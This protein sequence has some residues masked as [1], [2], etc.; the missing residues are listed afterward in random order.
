MLVRYFWKGGWSADVYG[1]DAFLTGH[2]TSSSR[3]SPSDVTL[4]GRVSEH[5]RWKLGGDH[6]AKVH[7]RRQGSR[8]TLKGT[9]VGKSP[10]WRRRMRSWRHTTARHVGSRTK[11]FRKFSPNSSC[12][13]RVAVYG[14]PGGNTMTIFFA[15]K[16]AS[17]NIASRTDWD[18]N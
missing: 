5:R 16:L 6:L 12:R 7:A 1:R 13:T 18:Y 4:A 15:W 2:D 9:S 8:M 14:P 11:S 17:R 10:V 3:W